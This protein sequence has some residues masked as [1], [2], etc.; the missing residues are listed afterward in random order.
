MTDPAVARGLRHGHALTAAHGRTY[1]AAAR[2]LPAPERSAVFALYGF[3]RIVDDVVDLPEEASSGDGQVRSR[4]DAIESALHHEFSGNIGATALDGIDQRTADIL[5]ALHDAVD[6]F[7]IPT[8][9]FDAFLRSMRMDVPGDPLF[10][11]RYRTWTEL[12]EYTHGSAAVIGIQMLPLLGVADPE[13]EVSAGAALLGNAFQLTNFLRDVAEDLDRDRIYLPT[14]EL[15][16][17]GV[18]EAHLRGCRDRQTT[19]PELRRA[20]AHLIAINRDQYRRCVP[21]IRAL[22]PRTRPA[23]A[24]AAAVYADILTQIERIDYA[25]LGHRATVPRVR[26]AGLALRATVRGRPD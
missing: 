8:D 22:P 20:L 21:S 15:A 25:V 24:S 6:R 3:A 4:I 26:R 23:I 9:T 7:D 17:F 13:P 2:L 11:N 14:T 1:H 18:D 5:A 10:R 19:S 16:A 12:A